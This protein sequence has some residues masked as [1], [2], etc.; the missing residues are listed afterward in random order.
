MDCGP[1]RAREVPLN[2][3]PLIGVS[4]GNPHLLETR[5]G[6]PFLMLGDTAWELFHRLTIEEIDTYFE[7]R[8]RQSFNMVWAN[9][10]PEF[11]G[12]RTPNRYGDK[13]LIDLDPAKPNDRYFRFV[14][15][16]LQIAEN[17]GLYLGLLPAWG[18]K[19]T[20]P[21]GDGPRIFGLDNLDR[22]RTYAGWLGERYSNATN[23]LWVLG[24][25][26]PARLFGEPGGFPMRNALDAGLPPDSDWTPIWRTMATGLRDAGATQLMT[27]HPQGGSQ[28]TSMFLHDEAWLDMNAMQSGHGGGHDVPVWESVSRDYALTPIKPTFDAE[29]NY[30]DHPVNPWPVWDPATGFFDDFDIRK[31]VYRSIFAGGCGVIYGNHCVWQFASDRYKPILE[32]RH[33]WK[34]AILSPGAESMVHLRSLLSDVDFF[35]LVPDQSR[36]LGDPGA[37]ASHARALRSESETLVYV[38]DGRSI[39]IDLA[40]TASRSIKIE[41]FDPQTGARE[42][43]IAPRSP[44]ARSYLS[45]KVRA[46]KDR[47]VVV[48][49]CQ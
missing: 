43:V 35:G 8:A 18:D 26:R 25:D 38:P 19:I 10:L 21:W 1:V 5:D 3:L 45:R 31:Q 14:D 28:S 22:I 46:G 44:D 40:W 23:I 11:D 39:E 34:E 30:E 29:P 37:G 7:T 6:R 16:V 27:Y 41:E 32:V 48:R 36:I 9:L 17:R 20:A 2:R 13:P 12:L 47:V 42:W 4:G 49:L 33:P 24:G 15:Q